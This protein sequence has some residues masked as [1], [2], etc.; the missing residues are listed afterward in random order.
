[1]ANSE[2]T[3]DEQLDLGGTFT[4][5]NTSMTLNRMGYRAMQLSGQDGGKRVWGPQRDVPGAITILRGLIRRLV[6][7]VLQSFLSNR[8]P[9]CKS[10]P[11]VDSRV[12]IEASGQPENVVVVG[13][14]NRLRS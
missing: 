7:A 3:N 11:Q 14:L 6:R 12:L 9:K 2:E 10:F 13:G 4:L 5:P 8:P 1:M